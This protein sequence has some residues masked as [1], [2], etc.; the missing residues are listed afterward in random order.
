MER[1][2][3]EGTAG[4]R[5]DHLFEEYVEAREADELPDA[6]ALLERAGPHSED[7]NHR[8]EVYEALRTLGR[9][10]RESGV[11]LR[12]PL[13]AP[14]RIERFEL[15]RP[16]GH[17]AHSRVYL[18]RDTELDREVAL[19]VLSPFELGTPDVRG[20]MLRE[21]RSLAA[22]DHEGIV[23]VLEVGEAHGLAYV[24][25]ERVHGAPLRVVL[26]ALGGQPHDDAQAAR[27]ARELRPITE[28]CQLAA[29]LAHALAYCHSRGVLHRDVKPENVL[30]TRDLRPVLV[31]FGLAYVGGARGPS[32]RVTQVLMG[33]PAY[34]SPEQVQQEATG[35]S[36]RSEI[37][38][39]GIILVELLTGTN[40]FERESTEETRRAIQRAVL[41]RPRSQDRE[42]PPDLERIALHC[43]E[44]RPED[45]YATMLDVAE[46]LEAFLDHR[47]ISLS[48]SP[49]ASLRGILR[50]QRRRLVSAA[51]VLAVL[52]VGAGLA[53]LADDH[54]DRGE[55]AEEV[56]AARAQLGALRVPDEFQV[57][58]QRAIEWRS[59]ASR[60]DGREV[61][62]L[63]FGPAVPAVEEAVDELSRRLATVLAV[64][65]A[66]TE[67]LEYDLDLAPWR[68]VLAQERAL[69]PDCVHNRVD[70]EGGRVTLELPPGPASVSLAAQRPGTRSTTRVLPVFVAHAVPDAARRGELPL[71]LASG[72]YRLQ[73]RDPDTLDVLREGDFPIDWNDPGHEVALR[74]VAPGVREGL[75]E[76]AWTDEDVLEAVFWTGKRQDLG[77]ATPLDLMGAR[78]FLLAREPVRWSELRAFA[79]AHPAELAALEPRSR[80]WLCNRVEFVH[81][82]EPAVVPWVVAHAYACWR[83][84]RL[85]TALELV[86]ALRSPTAGIVFEP[87][88]DYERG[89]LTSSPAGVTN[90]VFTVTYGDALWFSTDPYRAWFGASDTE[91]VVLSRTFRLALSGRPAR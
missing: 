82:D 41:P 4:D 47:A 10:W 21:G 20:W 44:A 12:P 52:L 67:A 56:A 23:R 9:D 68:G 48:T 62:T 31:D 24:A 75:V 8:M 86:C 73:V 58:F 7:L 29:Q 16:L 90:A 5:T 87:G 45:R 27:L 54:G 74:P 13:R 25:M 43:L 49:L 34:L 17:G 72:L 81:P 33:T 26:D 37:F 30:V 53:W 76:V 36:A 1:A 3:H 80:L 2:A 19:K 64:Q 32:P 22:L 78:T 46:D 42:I 61:P 59:R 51:L 39:F 71:T 88:P 6:L 38:S 70:R 50:R 40:P 79:E 83:G 66:R 14:G 35:S 69:C 89:E 15:V 77:S 85:P 55:L 57:A 11:E 28:R 63:L 65:R 18:A 91:G 84:A 60:L